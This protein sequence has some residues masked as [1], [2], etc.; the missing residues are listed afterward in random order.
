MI[1][2]ASVVWESEVAIPR[3]V[4]ELKLKL[5]AQEARVEVVVVVVTRSLIRTLTSL[6]KLPPCTSR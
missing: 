1:K 3:V 2:V 6:S 4:D 5:K